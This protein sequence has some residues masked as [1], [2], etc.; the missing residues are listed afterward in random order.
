MDDKEKEKNG[1]VKILDQPTM[2]RK[3]KGNETV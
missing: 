2:I 1:Y 3:L